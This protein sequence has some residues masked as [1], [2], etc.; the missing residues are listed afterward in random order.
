MTL[1]NIPVN[2][3]YHHTT[4]LLFT[5]FAV[6][7]ESPMIIF[8]LVNSFIHSFM[9]TYFACQ[10]V[11]IRFPRFIAVILTSMQILQMAFGIFVLHLQN[12]AANLGMSCSTPPFIWISGL[13]MYT[14]YFALFANFFVQ[15]Y[16]MNSRC[17][18]KGKEKMEII[19]DGN[20]NVK[21]ID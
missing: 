3:R 8:A 9:Y 13:L 18:K 11:G 5:W 16:L 12:K 7:H 17:G 4:V 1:I 20:Q 19:L 15:S 10:T 21:K 6:A 2:I 14:S